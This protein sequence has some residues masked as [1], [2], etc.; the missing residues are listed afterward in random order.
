M[1]MEFGWEDGRQ[2]GQIN[3][4]MEERLGIMKMEFGSTKIEEKVAKW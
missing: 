1:K 3:E 4:L 2:E